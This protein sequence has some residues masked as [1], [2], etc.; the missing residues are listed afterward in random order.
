MTARGCYLDEFRNVEHMLSVPI[1]LELFRKH[2]RIP[3]LARTQNT[4]LSPSSRLATPPTSP[5]GEVQ[6]DDVAEALDSVSIAF[7]DSLSDVGP[8]DLEDGELEDGELEDDAEEAQ[9]PASSE[10]GEVDVARLPPNDPTLGRKCFATKS[11]PGSALL[12]PHDLEDLDDIL[13]DID[14]DEDEDGDDDQPM[15]DALDSHPTRGGKGLAAKSLPS[16]EMLAKHGYD[17]LIDTSSDARENSTAEVSDAA[18]EIAL[19]DNGK[20]DDR[21]DFQA[22]A[23]ID[24]GD[25]ECESVDEAVRK[26]HATVE[27]VESDEHQ[28]PRA[29]DLPPLAAV[30]LTEVPRGGVAFRL[31]MGDGGQEASISLAS[32]NEASIPVASANTLDERVPPK[33]STKAVDVALGLGTGNDERESLVAPTL[34]IDRHIG[35]PSD[36]FTRHMNVVPGLESGGEE[37]DIV[38]AL[39]DDGREQQAQMNTLERPQPHLGMHPHTEPASGQDT[40]KSPAFGQKAREM[41]PSVAVE[42][43]SETNEPTGHI[44][45]HVPTKEDA[46]RERAEDIAWESQASLAQFTLP[47]A[48]RGHSVAL[49]ELEEEEEVEDIITEFHV[50]QTRARRETDSVGQ[51]QGSIAPSARKQLP[52]LAS[53]TS[54]KTRACSDNK[55]ICESLGTSKVS[56][57]QSFRSS[58][59]AADPSSGA[60][61]QGSAQGSAKKLPQICDHNSIPTRTSQ[62]SSASKPSQPRNDTSRAACR[63]NV[64]KVSTPISS[65]VDSLVVA[66]RPDPDVSPSAKRAA[67]KRPHADSSLLIS[68]HKPSASTP[69]RSESPPAKRMA[70]QGR[71]ICTPGRATSVISSNDGHQPLG[72]PSAKPPAKPHSSNTKDQG[73]SMSTRAMASKQTRP[74]NPHAASAR[75]REK[76][77]LGVGQRG[78]PPLSGSRTSLNCGA[79][80]SVE[81]AT[82]QP[83]QCRY[84]HGNGARCF[85]GDKCAFVHDEP[86]RGIFPHNGDAPPHRQSQHVKTNDFAS[87][88]KTNDRAR[89]STPMRPLAVAE[90]TSSRSYEQPQQFNPASGNKTNDMSRAGATTPTLLAADSTPPA[91]P[92]RQAQHINPAT[93]NKSNDLVGTSAPTLL[94]NKTPARS[95]RHPQH[96]NAISTIETSNLARASTSTRPAAEASPP[97]RSHRQPQHLNPS[98]ANKASD[99]TGP[100]APTLLAAESTPPARSYRQPQHLRPAFGNKIDDTSSTSRPTLSAAESA[101]LN[102]SGRQSQ[103]VIAHVEPVQTALAFSTSN[104]PST[105]W[106]DP[107]HADNDPA[108][109]RSPAWNYDNITQSAMRPTQEKPVP[110]VARAA[111]PPHPPAG[112]DSNKEFIPPVQDPSPASA[113]NQLAQPMAMLAQMI[114]AFMPKPQAAS[115]CPSE[116]PAA[117]PKRPAA[118]VDD[119]T[120]KKG[121]FSSI[122]AHEHVL[123]LKLRT[124][125]KTRPDLLSQGDK[126]A[127]DTI[128]AFVQR[129]QYLYRLVRNVLGDFR[130]AQE[131]QTHVFKWYADGL[132]EGPPDQIPYTFPPDEFIDVKRRPPELRE[133]LPFN[134]CLSYAQGCCVKHVCR[135]HHVSKKDLKLLMEGPTA[136]YRPR[137][138]EH[139]GNGAGGERARSQPKQKKHKG[140]AGGGSSDGGFHLAPGAYD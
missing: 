21:D 72:T 53:S 91:R 5:P 43:N 11:L 122:P 16:S 50:Q 19:D 30:E 124:K 7:S 79:Q 29:D 24:L 82:L 93:V 116:T 83:W 18:L 40:D 10:E 109:E 125:A 71:S 137:P 129:E 55:K 87:S 139:S 14:E 106:L 47:N 138:V 27:V 132:W 111:E 89:A 119:F 65:K 128:G 56:P 100:S 23:A 78:Q 46:A 64:N 4:Y 60:P 32:G 108:A 97:V 105:P 80:P 115:Q 6:T 36:H 69:S 52:P 121:P 98:S 103:P 49:S 95:Y 84:F 131:P 104:I 39:A 31:P 28:N 57:A 126:V 51:P 114:A 42:M 33:R 117:P 66:A 34:S 77:N 8:R 76:P 62:R 101:Q 45:N 48:S 85:L 12:S 61:G 63:A 17:Y 1:E 15:T 102:Q 94:V 38:R 130:K 118:A 59:R 113:L 123:Y 110:P 74:E 120:P 133:P 25:G 96:L 88:N 9:L 75:P 112:H 73:G 44:A 67:L 54:T 22:A 37:A 3:L 86:M 81:A 107:T 135:Y 68:A 41:R 90:T 70:T 140:R 99:L 127:L 134:Y 2:N 26:L 58:K 136:P 13:S 20:R 35:G 92:Y